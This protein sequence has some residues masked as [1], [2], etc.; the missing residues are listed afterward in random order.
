MSLGMLMVI[1][2]FFS[3]LPGRNGW[4]QPQPTQ[5]ANEDKPK[6][7]KE[8]EETKSALRKYA[9]AFI[10]YAEQKKKNNDLDGAVKCFDTAIKI[11]DEIIQTQNS[12]CPDSSK[13]NMS[14]K[15]FKELL[16][17]GKCK[18]LMSKTR[19]LLSQD[20]KTDALNALLAVMKS[21]DYPAVEDALSKEAINL[22]YQEF[23]MTTYDLQDLGFAEI[24]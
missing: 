1:F 8:Y 20:K 21:L 2:I 23:N 17:E 7:V 6:L 3:V 16:T 13:K 15:R 18:T 10:G 9:Q 24:K 11:Y 5:P 14:Y 12:K 22:L 19:I 4:S